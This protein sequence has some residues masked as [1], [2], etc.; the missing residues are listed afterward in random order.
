MGLSGPPRGQLLPSGHGTPPS[1]RRALRGFKA[2]TWKAS[3]LKERAVR[4]EGRLHTPGQTGRHPETSAG[5]GT[6]DEEARVEGDPGSAE[7]P[8]P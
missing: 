2:A 4:P 8:N 1:L 3:V 6:G 5:A 7:A